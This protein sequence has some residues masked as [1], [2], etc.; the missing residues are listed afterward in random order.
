MPDDNTRLGRDVYIALAAVGWADG[1]LDREEADAIV[2]TALEEGLDIDEI[3][4]IERATQQPIDLG[5]IDRKNLSKEDRL[6]VYAVASWMTRLDGVVSSAELSALGRLGDALKI[7]E[8]PRALVDGIAQDV[9]NLSDDRP[10]RYDLPALRR[11]IGERL[12]AAE[13]QRASA[14]D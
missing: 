9:A 2:R 3:A 14:K 6:F 8:R 1:Q 4:E 13:A 11:I 5:V 12:R 7:P 10:A